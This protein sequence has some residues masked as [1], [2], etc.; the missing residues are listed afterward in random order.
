MRFLV[1]SFLVCE[2]DLVVAAQDGGNLLFVECVFNDRV[3]VEVGGIILYVQ[4]VASSSK[5][6][7]LVSP[8][9]A[10]VV[11]NLLVFSG[12]AFFSASR[13]ANFACSCYRQ[14][15]QVEHHVSEMVGTELAEFK[16]MFVVQSGQVQHGAH[17]A[18]PRWKS[19]D[20]F[21]SPQLRE[22]QA[23]AELVD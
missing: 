14:H 2:L 3:L 13:L 9:F 11:R 6:L 15:V 20:S 16:L 5:E 7:A 10:L 18:R 1:P 19:S 8:D 12:R 17:L 22:D 4:F 21:G 23:D